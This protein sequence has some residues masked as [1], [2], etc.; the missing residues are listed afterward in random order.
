MCLTMISKKKIVVGSKKRRAIIDK[1]RKLGQFEWNHNSKINGSELS[2]SRRPN[3]KYRR[4]AIFYKTCAKCRGIYSLNGIRYHWR[5]CTRYRLV[6]E[7]IVRQLSRAVEGRLHEDADDDLRTIIFPRMHEDEEVLSIRFDWIVIT[8]GNDL[9]LNYSPHYQHAMIRT[10]LRNAGKLLLASKKLRPDITD[11]ASLYH[12][13]YCNTVIEA[14]R[15]IA[16]FDVKSK[17]FESPGTAAALVTLINAIGDLLIVESMIME[18]E[19]KEKMVERFLKVFQKYAKLKINKIVTV[20]QL[21]ARREKSENIPST[22]DVCRLAT[23]LDREREICFMELTELYSFENWLYLAQLTLMSVLVFNR[24]RVGDTQNILV[25]DFRR[26]EIITERCDT[27][28]QRTRDTIKSRITTRG[29]LYRTV[30]VLLKHNF[31]DCL[32]LL[33]RYRKDAGVHES[34]E[35]IFGLPSKS[36][37]IKVID[38]CALFQKYSELCGAENPSSLRGT[39][40]RK[41]FASICATMNLSDNDVSNVAKFMGHS[42]SVHRNV[43]RQNP[44]HQELRI[45]TF[46]DFAQGKSNTNTMTASDTTG[47]SNENS[48]TKRKRTKKMANV[49]ATKKPRKQIEKTNPEPQ[50]KPTKKHVNV[51]ITKKPQKRIKVT[52]S[53]TKRKPTKKIST[54]NVVRNKKTSKAKTVRMR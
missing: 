39:N 37:N 48:E 36:G 3:K 47:T 7:R 31:D 25:S 6:G 11:F 45:A 50:R 41:H 1:L 32:D 27:V 44:L 40:L 53:G 23:F 20:N 19:D 28:P 29:K 43:Y 33:L 9:C 14:I 42:D 2:T 46:L 54:V 8:F 22:D 35:Y 13:K 49:V 10:K 12:V 5:R 52:N 51:V 38:A 24:K 21:K 34:N 18:D 16:K 17:T 15:V 26:R 4:K 30:P